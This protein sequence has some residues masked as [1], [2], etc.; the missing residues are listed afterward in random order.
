MRATGVE[1]R[2]S[3][4]A[5]LS[6]RYEGLGDGPAAAHR[7]VAAVEIVIDEHG[8]HDG[9]RLG[10]R[11]G[12]VT[13]LREQHRLEVGVGDKVI[14][15]F[16]GRALVP[17]GQIG[18]GKGHLQRPEGSREATGAP[19]LV[20][21]ELNQHKIAGDA[22]L[23][24]GKLGHESRLVIVHALGNVEPKGI[25]VRSPDDHVVKAGRIQF[26]EREIGRDAQRFENAAHG[27]A[28]PQFT[29]VMNAGAVAIALERKGMAPATRR[30]VLFQHQHTLAR[31]R[32]RQRRS[33]TTGARADND[34]IGLMSHDMCL[35]SSRLM[36]SLPASRS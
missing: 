7:I 13:G 35:L 6:A 9:R 19:Q 23:L 1:R 12:I 22:R 30:L 28:R 21:H 24:M 8:V 25:P 27:F 5:R 15:Q 31:L 20:W 17:A 11:R 16:L 4:P 33:Q 10:G 34:D 32:Q 29:D 36:H 2:N 18:R 3:P 26:T 14:D